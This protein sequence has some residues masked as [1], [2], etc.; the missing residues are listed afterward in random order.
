M[1]PKLSNHKKT[2]KFYTELVKQAFDKNEAEEV[3]E[4]RVRQL[5]DFLQ[6]F[7]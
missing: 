2:L 3:K 1:K 5:L 6:A 7:V 4:L